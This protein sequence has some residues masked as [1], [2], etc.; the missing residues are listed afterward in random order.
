MARKLVRILHEIGHSGEVS[1]SVPEGFA[2]YAL[3]PM[4]YADLVARL[5]FRQQR[6][7][8][9]GIRSVGTT[10]SAVVCARLRQLGV[11]AERT[12]VRPTGHPYERRCEFDAA[13]RQAIATALSEDAAFFVCDEGP[14]RS[15]SSL[16][17]VAEALEREGVAAE[18][19]VILCS[20]EPDAN[21]LCAPDGARRWRR[22]RSAA[23][24]MTR[25]LPARAQVYAG[26][27][28]WRQHRMGNEDWPA[29]W[30]QMERLR[31]VSS[32]LRQMLTF[33]GHGAYGAAVAERNA[34]LSKSG[35]GVPYEGHE[36]GFGKHTFE[37]GRPAMRS[38]LTPRLLTRMAEYCAWRG[39]VF[40]VSEADTG[41]LEE[42]TRTN[43]A[44][45]FERELGDLELPAIYPTV[46]DNRMAPS[47][48]LV[49]EDGRFLKL[50][51]A[52]HGDDHFFP[53]PCDT[54]WDLAGAIVEWSLDAP[55][56]ER[57][58][59]RYRRLSGD[60]AGARVAAYEMAY[61]V[62]RMAWSKMAAASV[63]AGAER[64]RLTGDYAR[65]RQAVECRRSGGS[66]LM[67]TVTGA[68]APA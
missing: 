60:D 14:G 10:L 68:S 56:R 48:W 29:V 17:S 18:C 45:E 25:R 15:G 51:A 5:E 31:Y 6:A 19:I 16:L 42:A 40:A 24:G 67:A 3:H 28:E 22:Y 64:E 58:L 30:P 34:A 27:G 43:F 23:T 12:T 36:L 13:Q 2:Y 55:A 57:F 44:R 53:G 46:C 49:A 20:H 9:V 54:A 59:E 37:R 47:H 52:I 8:V 41:D 1:V 26:G 66:H 4:D 38:D 21:G 11:S 32:N 65:Y 39:G 7:F 50:D 62:F 61:S 35:F 33:E 63:G